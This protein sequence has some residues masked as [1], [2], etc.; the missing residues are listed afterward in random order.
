MAA[1]AAA[2]T[3]MMSEAVAAKTVPPAVASATPVASA[4]A[5]AGLGGGRADDQSAGEGD[6]SK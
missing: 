3:A 4:T 5:M 2:E 6:S 1:V